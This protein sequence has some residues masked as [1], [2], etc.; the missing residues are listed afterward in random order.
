MLR[1]ERHKRLALVAGSTWGSI[2]V[3]CAGSMMTRLRKNNFT[4]MSA[5][6][7]GLVAERT[8]F[9]AQSVDHATQS[10]CVTTT[11]VWKTP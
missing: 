5:G 4:V 11:S 9:T 6:S 8:S 2:S 1:I 7:V 10:T 3:R